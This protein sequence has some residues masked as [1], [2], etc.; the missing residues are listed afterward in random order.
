M[1]PLEWVAT[2]N[3]GRRMLDRREFLKVGASGALVLAVARWSR[4]GPSSE[5][6]QP[7]AALSESARDVLSAV[8]PAVLAGALPAEPS[9]RVA[10]IAATI[11]GV[12]R[13]VSGLPPH[14]RADLRDL[15]AL[16]GFAP[17]RWLLAGV[18]QPWRQASAEEI[19]R[20]LQRWRFSGW[21]LQQQA[22]QA[23]HELVYAAFYADPASWPPIGYPGP[24]NLA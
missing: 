15:F 16:L 5:G 7:G 8:V 14:A 22:Y 17:A 19:A 12:D 21:A 18:R 2:G 20:F 24:P 11:Q 4:A 10:R 3:D 9:A 13:A 6:A 1:R 23:L